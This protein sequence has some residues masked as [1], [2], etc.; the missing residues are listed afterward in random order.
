MAAVPS[1]VA[2]LR[3]GTRCTRGW[4]RGRPEVGKEQNDNGEGGGASGE[5]EQQMEGTEGTAE[6]ALGKVQIHQ[7]LLDS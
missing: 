6:N 1:R 4:R 3:R 5:V 7:T 2:E